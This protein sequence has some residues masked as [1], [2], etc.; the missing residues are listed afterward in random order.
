MTPRSRVGIDV[1]RS[2]VDVVDPVL[3]DYGHEH[4]VTRAILNLSRKSYGTIGLL[5]CNQKK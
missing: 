5:L 1:P 2:M 4:L 3:C